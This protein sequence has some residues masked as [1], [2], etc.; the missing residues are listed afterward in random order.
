MTTKGG[1]K[2]TIDGKMRRALFLMLALPAFTTAH[3]AVAHAGSVKPLDLSGHHQAKNDDGWEDYKSPTT[4]PKDDARFKDNNK[5]TWFTLEP[6]K[7]ENDY[8]DHALSREKALY[9]EDQAH[10][11][12]MT[13]VTG[14]TPITG[15]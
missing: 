2:M 12:P 10:R 15:N 9:D 5:S 1:D 11:D 8:A 6:T 3:I 14:G 4:S 13:S 7:P